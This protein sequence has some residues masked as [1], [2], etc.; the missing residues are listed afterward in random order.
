MPDTAFLRLLRE[1][2]SNENHRLGEKLGSRKDIQK[3]FQST[4]AGDVTLYDDLSGYYSM[5]EAIDK[6]L[7]A[8][9]E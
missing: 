3:H 2:L 5:V 8:S 9:E 1:W 7:A 6:E 4:Q